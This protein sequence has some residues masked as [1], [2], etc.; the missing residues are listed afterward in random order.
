MPGVSDKNQYSMCDPRVSFPKPPFAE[1]PQQAPG[2]AKEMKP[3]PD[4]GE[5]TYQGLGRLKGR[6]A[7]ITG[8]D[9]GIGKACAIAY[10]REGADVAINYLLSE[11]PDV[12]PLKALA[13]RE[14]AKLVCIPGDITTK[15][16]CL[17]LIE[18]AEQALGGLD[19]L[20][21]NAGKQVYQEQISDIS[22][23]QFDQTMKTN[24]YAMHWLSKAAMDIMPAGSSIINVT[25]IQ[26]YDPSTT[27][28]DYATTKF[29]I[30]GYTIAL[31]PQ[32][33]EK[34]IRVNAVAPGPVWTPLQPS[35]GQTQE[36][37]KQFGST[38]PIGRP[39]QP[40]ELASTFVFLASQESGYITGEIIGVT[41][42]MPLG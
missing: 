35:G 8:G 34:G 28:L 24:I 7:L 17:D 2:L 4:H 20:V 10:M 37:L 3:E 11:E 26:G 18:R 36:N 6:K 25:S 13:D 9:S 14:G 42:G 40:V 5:Q 12:E 41:G 29:A 22:D 33:M 23:E 16:V 31:A 27:L 39:G 38:T 19:I 32:A 30:R 21:L 1:Q 15:T